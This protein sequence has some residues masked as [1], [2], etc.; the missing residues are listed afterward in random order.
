MFKLKSEKQKT[1]YSAKGCRLFKYGEYEK[2]YFENG[3]KEILELEPPDDLKFKLF[4]HIRIY[5]V[6][7]IW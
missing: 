2:L 5:V 7:G 6:Y 1:L 3:T 4:I